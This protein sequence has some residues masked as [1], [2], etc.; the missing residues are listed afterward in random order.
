MSANTPSLADIVTHTPVW[1]WGLLALLIWRGLRATQPREADLR[2]LVMLPLILLALSLYGL[3]TGPMTGMVGLG[4]LLGIGLGVVAGMAL[5]ARHPAIPVAP[6]GLQL[7]G[8]WTSLMTILVMFSL[9]Y[10]RS[11]LD[12]VQPEALANPVVHLASTGIGVFVTTVLLTRTAQR[13]NILRQ[14]AVAA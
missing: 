8:E 2:G 6:G 5:E 12:A 14:G 3:A 9:R 11:V 1:V 10:V 4:L 7:A 13:L